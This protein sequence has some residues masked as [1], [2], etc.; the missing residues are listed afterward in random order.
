MT[1]G[2]TWTFPEE[3]PAVVSARRAMQAFKDF[4]FLLFA[5]PPPPSSFIS[6]DM[7]LLILFYL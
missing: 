6:I 3:A 1:H 4:L 5:S 7:K 2:H